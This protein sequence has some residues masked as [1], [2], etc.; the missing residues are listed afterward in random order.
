MHCSRPARLDDR[1]N[2]RP[3]ITSEFHCCLGNDIRSRDG[4]N[5]TNTWTLH[6]II[7]ARQRHPG[8]RSQM[9]RPQDD[10][11]STVRKLDGG[12]GFEETHHVTSRHAALLSRYVDSARAAD[13]HGRLAVMLPPVGGARSQAQILVVVLSAGAS[14]SARAWSAAWIC[15]NDSPAPMCPRCVR[16]HS[17]TMTVLSHPLVQPSGARAQHRRPNS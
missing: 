15:S 2:R 7:S 12:L 4:P 9:P 13:V 1:N 8:A 10:C 17:I 6:S 14:T 16:H 3:G 5:T 11:T